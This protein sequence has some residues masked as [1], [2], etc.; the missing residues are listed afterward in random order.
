M[1]RTAISCRGQHLNEIK[2]ANEKWLMEH[3]DD[4]RVPA[5]EAQALAQDIVSLPLPDH[6]KIA[7]GICPLGGKHAKQDDTKPG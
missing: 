2:A 7:P 1:L 6:A 5:G 4:E 3:I